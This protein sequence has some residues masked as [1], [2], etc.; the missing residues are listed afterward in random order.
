LCCWLVDLALTPL[1]MLLFGTI[2]LYALYVLKVRLGI[3]IFPS[4]GVH[5]PGPRTLVKKI[6]RL[7]R[8]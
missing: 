2:G 5:L 4:G 3:D 1:G 7:L 8:P 6:A